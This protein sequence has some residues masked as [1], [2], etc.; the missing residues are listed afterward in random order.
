MEKIMHGYEFHGIGQMDTAASV[1]VP[2]IAVVVTD[3]A[4]P[5]TGL[6][7]HGL[8]FIDQLKE[9]FGARAQWTIIS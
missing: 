3:D 5:D 2:V 6:L 7:S 1:T 8:G 9:S 4:V